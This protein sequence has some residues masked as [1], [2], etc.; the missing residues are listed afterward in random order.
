MWELRIYI[1]NMR[2]ADVLQKTLKNVQYSQE[3]T[4]VG[5]S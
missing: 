2:I 1:I 5:V 3:N 4:C